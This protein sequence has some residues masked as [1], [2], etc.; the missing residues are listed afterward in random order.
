M[1]KYTDVYQNNAIASDYGQGDQMQRKERIYQNTWVSPLDGAV[2]AYRTMM[3]H[4]TGSANMH[5]DHGPFDA[6]KHPT[7]KFV[8]Q[9][10]VLK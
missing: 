9:C 8:P 1:T 10:G 7:Y 5:P 4:F 3:L 2:N 6:S